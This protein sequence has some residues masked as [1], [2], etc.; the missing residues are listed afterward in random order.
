MMFGIVTV[1]LTLLVGNCWNHGKNKNYVP[2]EGGKK[3]QDNPLKG[4]GPA[5]SAD[6]V[7]KKKKKKKGDIGNILD[8]PPGW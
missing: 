2:T 4:K 6:E 7:E 5:V 1:L 3:V 8:K